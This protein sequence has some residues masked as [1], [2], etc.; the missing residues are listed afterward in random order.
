MTPVRACSLRSAQ[1]PIG[2]SIEA[3]PASM[4]WANST[5]PRPGRC[6]AIPNWSASCPPH[7]SASRCWDYAASLLM[8]VGKPKLEPEMMLRT[9]AAL[10]GFARL[11]SPASAERPVQEPAAA[12]GSR[13]SHWVGS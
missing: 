6:W 12:S 13:C 4:G 5:S 11:A 9:D 3:S 8:L 10:E 1:P 7:R 2:R